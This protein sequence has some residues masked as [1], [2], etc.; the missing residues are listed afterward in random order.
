MTKPILI[1]NCVIIDD[2]KILLIKRV[3]EHYVGYWGMPGGRIEFA[4]HV[5]KA[6]VR[7]FKEE[8][9]FVVDGE[10]INLGKIKQPSYKIIYA[11]ALEKDLDATR[12]KSNTFKIEWPKNSGRLREYPEIDKARWFKIRDAKKKIIKGQKGF[13]DILIDILN[14]VPKEDYID[15]KTEQK[16]STLF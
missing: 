4:E 8:T 10:M 5:E 1:V 13:I 9:G 15:K 3:K 14:F 6:A 11:W 7:E 16:Q 2:N 12:I